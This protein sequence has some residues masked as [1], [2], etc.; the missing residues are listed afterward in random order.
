MSLSIDVPV[1]NDLN[2]LIL[3]EGADPTPSSDW[4]Y[5]NELDQLTV[6]SNDSR[7]SF[8]GIN[9]LNLTLNNIKMDD[10]GIYTL[11]VANSM[12]IVT[13]E[14]NVNVQCKYN[15]YTLST[16]SCCLLTFVYN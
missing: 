1:G 2:I 13:L 9:N 11:S 15:L 10:G 7:I 12:D 16:F 4:T 3:F 5:T 6:L 8:S 14:F